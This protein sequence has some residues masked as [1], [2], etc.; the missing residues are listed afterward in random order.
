[1]RISI[2]RLLKFSAARRKMSSGA[3]VIYPPA[4]IKSVIDKTAEFVAKMGDDFEKKVAVQQAGQPKFAFLNAGNP[5]RKYYELRIQELREGRESSKP[6]MPQ[7]LQDLKAADEEKR[8]KRQER[9]MIG[10]GLVKEYPPPPPSVFVLEHPYIAP[11]DTDIIKVCAQYVARNGQKF[12]Q[13]LM[14]RESRNPQFEFLKPEHHLY[15]YFEALV[16]SYTKV[17]LLPAEEK[18]K[19][20]VLSESKEAILDRITSRYQYLAQEEK[21]KSDKARLENE[22]KEGMSRLDWF[23]F[24][25]VGKLDFPA[26]ESVRL[27]IP[28][29]PRTGRRFI[30]GL[31][32]PMTA[33][34]VLTSEDMDRSTSAEEVK[35]EEEVEMEQALPVPSSVMNV[36]T[37]YV[38]AKKSLST[39]QLIKS[40]I[41]GEMIRESEFSDHM[42]VVLQDPQYRRQCEIVL[43]RAREEASALAEDI[44][45]NI[46]DFVRKRL[47]LFGQVEEEVQRPVSS[48]QPAM[49]VI[50][51]SL[52]SSPKRSR[53]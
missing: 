9:K 6:V 4:D 48:G 19:I 16:D 7:A 38:R 1:M 3:D 28:I 52:P 29:D 35:D 22:R 26:D 36:R 24:A 15:S 13:G 51:P 14:T 18:E 39:E 11:V 12:L 2:E 10:D 46:S 5:Y 43:K 37:D 20:R 40:P 23:N 49:S 32:V 50:G 34:L 25:I 31:P 47:H 53:Q 41:T 33:G 8:K 17:L 44:G 27:E 45:D 21:R 42:R 30:T